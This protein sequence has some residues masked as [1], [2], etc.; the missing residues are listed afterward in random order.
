[1]KCSI[2]I[3]DH[4]IVFTT[5]YLPAY[6]YITSLDNFF[7][8]DNY[9]VAQ[10]AYKYTLEY[11]NSQTVSGFFKVDNTT[12]VFA[13]N[14][15]RINSTTQLMSIIYQLIELDRQEN[16]AFLLHASGVSFN[17]NAVLLL[18]E[19]GAGKTS[20][21]LRLCK[22]KN[23]KMISNDKLSLCYNDDLKN[24]SVSVGSRI[25]NLRLSGVQSNNTCLLPEI[26]TPDHRNYSDKKLVTTNELGIRFETESTILKRLVIVDIREWKGKPEFSVFPNLSKK[27]PWADIN[28]LA[29]YFSKLIRGCDQSMVNNEK[30]LNEK[31]PPPMLDTDTTYK[32]RSRFVNWLIDNKM[33]FSLHANIDDA[34]KIVSKLLEG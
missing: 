32:N 25:I 30:R 13:E 34:E 17:G 27:N 1:M 5:Q 4:G 6:S 9:S 28:T 23:F 16:N 3:F 20:L 24:A 7:H 31:M 22:S 33:C 15:E 2:S 18:G 14:W 11:V 8:I 29:S 21:M 19:A 10:V 26:E 12:F